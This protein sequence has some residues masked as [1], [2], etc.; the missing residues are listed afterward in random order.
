MT[1][2]IQTRGAGDLKTRYRP[3]RLSEMCPTFPLEDAQAVLQDPNSA[4]VYLLEGLTGSGKTT[5]ARILSRASICVCTDPGVEKPCLEC[6]P[7]KSMESSPDFVEVN[8]ADFRGIDA[9]RDQTRDMSVYSTYLSRRIYIFDEVH[10]LT[11][12][13]QELLNKVLEEPK[14]NTLIFLC[15]THK[16]G[17]KRTLL[18]RCSKIEFSRMSQAQCSEIIRQVAADQ[19]A[20]LPDRSTEEDLFMRADGSVR[21]LLNLLDK[22][23]RGTYKIG[24]SFSSGDEDQQGSPDI[25]ALVKAYKRKDWTTVREILSTE[26]V[27]ND[28]DGYRETVC[29]FLAKEALDNP[30]DMNIAT[31][32]GH[33]CGSM[34]QEPTREQYSMLVLRSMRACYQ[35]ERP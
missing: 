13:A 2:R 7:C 35:K 10:Q 29:A 18:S 28:P 31:A 4:R 14:G 11:A 34:W 21:E 26:N 22:F 6:K 15:T 17:L 5:L 23:F 9:I 25:F 30:L 20:K 12:A 8:I 27:K 16:K 32:L 24:A 33:L 3:K 1:F 19:K